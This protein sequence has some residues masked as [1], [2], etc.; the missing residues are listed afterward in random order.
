MFLLLP[1]T[2]DLYEFTNGLVPAYNPELSLPTRPP[3]GAPEH[4]IEM[5]A[6]WTLEEI[7]N[8][9]QQK[10]EQRTGAKGD[11][12]RSAFDMFASKTKINASEF[13]KKIHECFGI[14]LTNDQ[15][16]CLF[17]R[18]VQQ[19]LANHSVSPFSL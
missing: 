2:V 15:L 13:H 8:K 3:Y 1:G 11:Y 14:N 19:T 12:F 4:S 9:L 17:N 6:L 7:E 5:Q 18:S 16:V 10:I